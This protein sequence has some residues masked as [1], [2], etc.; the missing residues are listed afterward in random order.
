MTLEFI[1]P[2]SSYTNA[3]TFSI[4]VASLAGDFQLMLE[5]R[6]NKNLLTLDLT[7]VETNERY[8]EFS[9]DYTDELGDSDYSGL[10]DFTITSG[11]A[12]IAS[13]LCKVINNRIKSLDNETKY[14]SPN[15]NGEAY[16][17]Y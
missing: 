9:T 11:S 5:S 8:T 15:E 10:Y 3:I 6:Y 2:T 14:I 7:I 12:T 16:V 4:D 17:I 1:K 13:G